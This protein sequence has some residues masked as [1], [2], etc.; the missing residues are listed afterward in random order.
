MPVKDA[1]HD[2]GRDDCV[3]GV[4]GL[5]LRNPS[6]RHVFEIPSTCTVQAPHCA[7]PQPY[8]VPVRPTYPQHPQQRSV[9]LDLDVLLL[10]VDAEFRHS[11]SSVIDAAVAPPLAAFADDRSNSN[12]VQIIVAEPRFSAVSVTSA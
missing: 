8:L 2:C 5:E 1:R 3:A 4:G 9:G 6:A 10:S 7:M 12:L 11:S